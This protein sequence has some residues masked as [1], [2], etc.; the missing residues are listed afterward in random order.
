VR[1]RIGVHTGAPMLSPPTYVGLDVHRAARVMQAGHGG[2]VLISEATRQLLADSGFVFRDLGEH[3][4]KDL[5]APVRLYQLG[6]D[7][8]PPLRSIAQGDLP[9][10][11]GPLVGREREV[12]E[13]VA[14]LRAGIRIFTLTGAGG[15]WKTRLA[16][17]A[18]AE[19][20]P[21]YTDGV[22]F[23]PLAAITD[24]A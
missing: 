23:V 2:Q 5:A 4:L 13:A 3:R 19:L 16:V 10:Q 20:A 1:V 15:S 6:N 7:D 14:F 11:T 17:Q 8:F 24:A 21:L 18:A 22:W 9:L 12:A